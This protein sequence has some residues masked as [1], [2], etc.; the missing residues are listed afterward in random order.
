MFG[1]GWVGAGVLVYGLLLSMFVASIRVVSIMC[2]WVLCSVSQD[3][4][5]I[6]VLGLCLRYCGCLTHLFVSVLLGLLL[7]ICADCIWGGVGVAWYAF[8]VL[9]RFLERSWCIDFVRGRM[10]VSNRGV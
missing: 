8:G 3:Y 7:G 9:W 2:V 10:C 6:L 1:R 5:R 4:G